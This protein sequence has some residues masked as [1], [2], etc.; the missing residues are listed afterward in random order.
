MN[1]E[2]EGKMS[3]VEVRIVR[4]E[5]MRVACVSGFGTSPEEEAWGKLLAWA[6]PRGLLDDRKAHRIFGFDNPSPS[7]GSP[8]YGYDFWIVVGPDVE[9]EG[10]ATIVEFSGGLYAVTRCKGIGNI[11]QVWKQL[12]TWCEDSQYK[13]AHHQWLEEPLSGLDTPPDELL[14]DLYLPIAE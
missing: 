12:V 10:E 9:A 5:P 1:N 7:P 8:N 13:R 4:L 2:G 14:L 11:G 3:E 6:K